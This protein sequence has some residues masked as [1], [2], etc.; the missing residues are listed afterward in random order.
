[1]TIENIGLHTISEIVDEYCQEIV[2]TGCHE[3]AV[4]GVLERFVARLQAELADKGRR[5]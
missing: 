1:M 4:R 5:R 2:K 3:P